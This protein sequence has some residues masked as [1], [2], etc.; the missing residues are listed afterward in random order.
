MGFPLLKK[1]DVAPM[2]QNF[3]L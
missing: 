1:I 3:I 2:G